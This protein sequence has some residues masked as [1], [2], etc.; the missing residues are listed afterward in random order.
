M[1]AASR[2]CLRH[3]LH[4][5]HTGLILKLR[6]GSLTVNHEGYLLEAAYA[7]LVKRSKLS[8]PAVLHCIACIHPV[9]VGCKKCRLISSDTCSYL[10]VNV[11]VVVR[12]LRQQQNPQF[13]FHL[14]YNVSCGIKLL[15][16]HIP[17]VRI[18][19]MLKHIKCSITVID[20]TLIAL[21][22]LSY[23]LEI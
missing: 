2:L 11:F 15:L 12:I 16:K 23:R 20:C 9:E 22:C 14:L 8:L 3:A 6:V 4:S 1:Y 7:Y 19:F 18:I 17:H 5:V 21:I 10:H 13:I